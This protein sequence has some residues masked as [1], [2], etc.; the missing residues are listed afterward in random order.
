M[1]Q[2]AAQFET[3]AH[4]MEAWQRVSAT[5]L[6]KK[7]VKTWTRKY[8]GIPSEADA[9]DLLDEVISM[10][11]NVNEGQISLVGGGM[12]ECTITFRTAEWVEPGQYKDG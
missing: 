6:R 12:W 2:Y 11:G 5:Q 1:A 8:T 3:G 7:L 4:T 10:F 9:N